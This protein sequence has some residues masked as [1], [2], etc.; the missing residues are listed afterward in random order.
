MKLFPAIFVVLTITIFPLCISH[1][2][3]VPVGCYIAET[4]RTA[5]KNAFGYTPQ[6]FNPMDGYLSWYTHDQYNPRQIYDF[7]GSVVEAMLKANYDELIRCAN[8][9]DASVEEY[10]FLANEYNKR[11][12]LEKK[13]RRAC[14]L[15][16]RRLK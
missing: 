3:Q 5:V 4:E 8:S 15:R 9:Y 1:A 7:Y 10:N 12:A 13:L 11:L 16:C 2:E 14:G 6:C